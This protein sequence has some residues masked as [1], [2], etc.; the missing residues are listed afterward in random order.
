MCKCFR[1]AALEQGRNTNS[2]LGSDRFSGFIL[3]V[4]IKFSVS[5]A[6]F[7]WDAW[8]CI[9][10][11]I[12]GTGLIWDYCNVFLWIKGTGLSLVLLQCFFVDK[13]HWPEF[14]IITMFFVDKRHWPEF[15]II[16]MLFL[17]IKGSA[18]A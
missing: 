4:C 3:A 12:R 15:G 5:V 6:L 7:T 14:G 10:Q 9:F 16:T 2:L 18:L 1:V 17:W 11:W 13:R 8:S